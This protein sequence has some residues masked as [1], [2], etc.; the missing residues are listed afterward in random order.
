MA[1]FY[2]HIRDGEQLIEDHIGLD[3]ANVDEARREA[4]QSAR[5]LLAENLRHGN[6]LDNRR[7]EVWD[8]AGVPHFILPFKSVL[9]P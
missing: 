5:E 4:D 7:Y 1:R 9:A 3:L 2:F 6:K 8:D